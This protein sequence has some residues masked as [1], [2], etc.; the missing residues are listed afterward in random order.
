MIGNEVVYLTGAPATGKSTTAHLL[1][2]MVGAMTLSYGELLTEQLAHRVKSQSELR[3]RSSQVIEPKEVRRADEEMLR[4]VRDGRK[5]SMVVVDSHALTKESFGF[6]AVPYSRGE[7]EA[8]AFTWIICLYASPET[9]RRRISAD[10]GGRPLPSRAD[11]ERHEQLQGSLAL[12]Y[13]HTLGI[14]VAFIE[15]DA[16]VERRVHQEGSKSHH[17]DLVGQSEHREGHPKAHSRFITVR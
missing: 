13:A 11:L 4:R 15:Y 9:I 12:A 17:P 7:L 8:M 1:T 10:S 3:A 16:A 2:S 14:P 6:R 5:K